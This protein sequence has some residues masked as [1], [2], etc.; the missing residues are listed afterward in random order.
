MKDIHDDEREDEAGRCGGDLIPEL[1]AQ[2]EGD[3]GLHHEAES[4]CGQQR[5]SEYRSVSFSD[6]FH[7]Y[8]NTSKC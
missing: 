8:H 5:S 3:C 4:V 6:K 7:Y 1:V 2:I